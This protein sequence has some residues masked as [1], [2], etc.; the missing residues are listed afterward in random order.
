M[1][2]PV[3]QLNLFCLRCSACAV[4]KTRFSHYENV[5][6]LPGQIYLVMILG[7]CNTSA[8]INI[9]GEQK[10]LKALTLFDFPGQNVS[11]LARFALK[12]IKIMSRAYA[13]QYL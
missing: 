8:S 9:E 10:S 7:A 11:D 1:P 5:E 6:E 13:L 4:I 2:S 12:H 3:W